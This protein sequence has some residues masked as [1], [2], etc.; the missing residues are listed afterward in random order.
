VEQFHAG[1]CDSNIDGGREI[2]PEYGILFNKIYVL[3]PLV[4]FYEANM[5]LHKLFISTKI[6][7]AQC[8][9]LQNDFCPF[10]LVFLWKREAILFQSA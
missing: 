6:V 5:E 7:L 2:P 8:M 10:I 9:M 1:I 3:L 4:V